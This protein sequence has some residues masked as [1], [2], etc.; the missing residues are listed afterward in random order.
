M[1]TSNFGFFAASMVSIGICL[2]GIFMPAR[3]AAR[4]L[5]L[6]LGLGG[7]A[8]T[9]Y[10]VSKIA[11]PRTQVTDDHIFIM[12]TFYT[13][14]EVIACGAGALTSLIVVSGLMLF[15]KWKSAT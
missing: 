9:Q 11:F 7:I 5:C 15:S 3:S 4:I 12:S 10:H 13:Q 8:F 1:I 6:A 2:S 14:P